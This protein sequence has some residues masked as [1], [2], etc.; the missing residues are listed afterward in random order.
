MMCAEVTRSLPAWAP[1]CGVTTFA[2]ISTSTVSPGS[3]LNVAT[4][5]VAVDIGS[6]IVDGDDF[7]VVAAMG[8]KDDGGSGGTAA[9]GGAAA[10]SATA[11]VTATSEMSFAG[12]GRAV[13]ASLAAVRADVA[14]EAAEAE[15]ALLPLMTR[16]MDNCPSPAIAALV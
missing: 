12:E 7:V 2:L 15:E 6:C 9:L 5:V 1:H 3:R 4:V 10:V 11:V 13:A 14:A 8:P 16:A